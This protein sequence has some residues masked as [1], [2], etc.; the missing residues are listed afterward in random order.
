MQHGQLRG[1][2]NEIILL[3]PGRVREHNEDSVTIVKNT[4]E[5]LR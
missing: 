1:E 2:L 3:D 5:H 4:D